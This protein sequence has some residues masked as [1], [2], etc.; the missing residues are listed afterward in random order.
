M[1]GSGGADGP[2]GGGSGG[3]PT[4]AACGDG[5]C[6]S[7]EDCA[8]CPTDCG[9]CTDEG[10]LLIKCSFD[11]MQWW[12]GT[13]LRDVTFVA[14]GDP[15]A[16]DPTPGCPTD[17]QF[18]ADQNLLIAEAINSA[19]AVPHV[20]PTG[21]SFYRE[22]QPYDHIRGVIIAGDLT[23]AGSESVPAGSKICREYT[24]Y[25]DAFGRCGDEGK[26]R[27][28]VYDGYGNHD[29]PLSPGTGDVDH[30]PVID[31]LDRLTIDYRPGQPSDGY[32]DATEGTGHYAWRWDD[33][34]FV[35]LNLKQG[36]DEEPIVKPSTNTT[37]I[38][39]PHDSLRFLREFLQSRTDDGTRQIVI[40]AHYPP[41]SSRVTGDEK[42]AFCQL[43]YDAQHGTGTFTGQK[44]SLTNPVVAYVHGHTHNRP[45]HAV[46]SCPSAYG[47]EISRFDVGTPFYHPDT[48]NDDGMLHFT[49]FRIGSN[50]L[51][52]VGVSAPANG[53]TGAWTYVYQERLGVMVA[54]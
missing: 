11:P 16:I 21:S 31:Y 24:A 9:D 2:G 27:F 36:Y 18:E 25:R 50:W 19:D 26:L 6:G 8:T 54:P 49:V 3:G 38:A 45:G 7:A 47:I 32:D 5:T 33:I 41:G 53:P 34:W 51:E 29:F 23:Q 1:G 48:K 4:P 52:V 20:W 46:Y 12:R 30:H 40:L 44:L 43:L 37:R 10:D 14:F 39:D 35:S 15:Q 22:G 13:N 17:G 42:A 28:P